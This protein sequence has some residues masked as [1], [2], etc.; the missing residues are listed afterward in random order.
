MGIVAK[1][2]RKINTGSAKP[3]PADQEPKAKD[4]AG[5]PASAPLPARLP[6]QPRKAAG[7]PSPSPA[8]SV[9]KPGIV[10]LSPMAHALDRKAVVSPPAGAAAQP[11]P[12]AA[13]Q[14]AAKPQPRQD[15]T[16]SADEPEKKALPEAAKIEPDLVSLANPDGP[17]AELFKLLRTRILFPPSGRPPRTILVTSAV[18]EEGKSFVASNLA[19]NIAKNVDE[20]V[21]LVDCDLRKPSIHTKFGF[22]GVKGL[23]EYLT[24]GLELSSLF[25]KTGVA[26]LTLLT[27]GAPPPNPSELITSSKMAALIEELKARYDDRYV[28]L[29][30]PPPLMAPETSAIA[31]WVDGILVVVKFGT[32]MDLVQELVSHLDREKIIG[33]VINKV[34]QREFRSYSYKKYYTNSKYHPA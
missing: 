22:N 12:A 2:I 30:S 4:S 13:P 7:S 24:A 11:Q 15:S 20:H 3:A 16:Q 17:E 6:E 10:R 31:Q 1:A 28:I 32:P 5:Q 33:V 8:A 26:K 27:S 14:A 9:E 25:L 29:D 19:V 18:A 23:S 34:N 21:L